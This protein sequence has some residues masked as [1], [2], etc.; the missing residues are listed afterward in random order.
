[1]NKP[2][3]YLSENQPA[4]HKFIVILYYAGAPLQVVHVEA[5]SYADA[6]IEVAPGN[7]VLKVEVIGV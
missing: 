4:D 7:D 3:A 1:M 6:V 5:N 2:D